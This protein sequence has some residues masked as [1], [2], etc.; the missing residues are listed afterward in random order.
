MRVPGSTTPTARSTHGVP[1]RGL[2]TT[3]ASSQDTGRFGRMFR[4]LPVFQCEEASLVVLAAAMIQ[5]FEMDGAQKFLDK[6]LGVE[7]EDENTSRLSNGEFRLPSG[8]TYFGQF[9]DHDITF[10]PVSSLHRQNDPDALVDFRTPRFD[11]DSV[12]GKGPSDDPFAYED[13]LKLLEGNPLGPGDRKDLPRAS[14]DRAIIGDPRNDENKIVSQLQATFIRFHNRVVDWVRDNEP[15]FADTPDNHFKRAQQIVRWHYQWVVIQDFLRRITGDDPYTPDQGMVAD[16]L[17]P[18]AYQTGDS[19][20]EAIRPHLL[21]YRWRKQ[22]YIPVEFSVAAYRFGHTMARPSYHI[23]Q[24]LLEHRPEPDDVPGLVGVKAQRIPFFTQSDGPRDSMN[25]FASIPQQWGVDWSFLL[26]LGD[27]ANLP[28]PSYK[29]DTSLV[30]PLGALP[31][32]VAKAEILVHGFPPQIAQS[33]ACRNLLR[34]LRLG[35]PGGEHVARAM[36]VAPDARIRI[37]ADTLKTATDSFGITQQQ[38]DDTVADLTGKTPL[39]YYILKEGELREGAHLGPVGAR[40]VAE[41]LIGLLSGDPLSYLSVQPGWTPFLPRRN[42]SSE[43]A[44]T[45][46]DLVAFG[47][48]A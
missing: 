15:T 19:E 24:F 35:L 17:R 28:Q 39:W 31:D 8:Y 48:G 26:P 30:N 11:L 34:G 18:E 38:V 36:G 46:A 37:D 47:A 1:P 45:L 14:N 13:G 32:R 44:Y 20:E 4:R 22:P 6:P 29:L 10:D 25:G 43:G 16:I 9:V 3:P 21:F 40:I 27:A 12:Y 23:N 42:G 7:D 5:G 33:L 2:E 41:V